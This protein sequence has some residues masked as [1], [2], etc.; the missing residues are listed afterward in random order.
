M[1]VFFTIALIL[2]SSV[3]VFAQR[4]AEVIVTSTYLRK[5]P[6][7][8]AEKIQTLQKGEKITIE[9]NRET[10]GWYYVSVANGTVKGWILGETVRSL[11]NEPKGSQTPNKTPN[12]T[13]N[14]PLPTILPSPTPTKSTP[15]P[16]ASP[17]PTP[18]AE[19]V[20]DTEVVK[21]DTEEV[22]LSVRVVDRNNRPV[23]KLSQSDF[24]VYEDGVLQPITSL[25]TAEVPI[26]NALLI[27]NSRSLRTQ[28]K[29]VIEASKIIVGTNR[30]NDETSV[31]RFISSNK[32]EVVQD[33]T[34]DKTLLNN[35]LDN[36]FVDGGQTAII[37]A[38]YRAAKMVGEYQNSGK[39]EDVK[40]RT[41]ILVS[42]GDDRVSIF[43]ENQLFE[44]L[45]NSYVQI[46]AIGFINNLSRQ[47]EAE[48]N[49]SRQ[50]KAKSFLTRLAQ[51]TGGKVYFPDSID[52]LP[53]IAAEISGE[54]RTQYFI[55]Y[56]P[57]NDRH[58]G[59]FRK[60]KVVVSDGTNREERIAITRTGRNAAPQ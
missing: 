55:S 58:D 49:I 31:V 1:K 8:G 29:K 51:E 17:S 33:F 4:E 26:I 60:I 32:I 36:L 25:T 42:D 50:E 18:A 52:E 19:T 30:P 27:D 12:K 5:A 13:P 11:K 23:N 38:V 28:L 44:L 2:L 37:D 7:Y 41:L 57:T 59:G 20:E 3:F 46:Y 54:L 15:T 47:P 21:I 39:K 40:L 22:S 16:L 24:K 45:R 14:Q 35:A 43:Q 53:K 56:A 48:T 34:P 10:N 9:K 6:D